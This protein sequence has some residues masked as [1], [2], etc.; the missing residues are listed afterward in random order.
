MEAIVSWIKSVAMGLVLL[1]VGTVRASELDESAGKPGDWGIRPAA[2]ETVS[3][4]PPSFSWRPQEGASSYEIR[5]GQDDSF[6]QVVYAKKGWIYNVHTPPTVLGPGTYF[7]RYRA[8]DAEGNTTEWS[9]VRDFEVSGSAKPMPLPEKNELLSRIPRRH[10]R[11]F[12]RPEQM[13]ELRRRAKSDLRPFYERLVA[14]CEQLL[15]D[16][17]PTEEPP[18]YSEDMKRGSDPWRAVWWGNRVYTQRVMNGAATLAFTWLLDGNEK[19]GSAARDLLMACAKWDPKGSTGYR[20]N[21]EAGMP[22]NYYFSRTYTFLYDL[23]S[24]EERRICRALMKVRGDEMNDHL[25]PSHFW[26]PYGSHQNRAWHFLGEIGV[27]FLDEVEG[28]D[29]WVWF[30]ANVFMNTYPVWSDD[31]GGWHEGVNYWTSYQMRF[32]WWADIM[33]AAMGIDAFQKPYYSKAGDYALYLQPPGTKGG[34]FGD[35]TARRESKDNVGLMTILA[36]QAQNPYWQWYVEAHGGAEPAQGYVGFIRGA[37]PKVK[38]KAPT[39][40]PASM[41][42]RGVGQACL[43]ATLIDAEDNVEVIFKSSPFGTWS[44]GYESQN[45]FLLYAYGERLFIRTGRRDSYGSDHHKQWMWH[46]KSV[47]SITVEGEG[48]AG[49]SQEAKGEIT[50][51]HTSDLI[52]YVEGE[53]GYAYDGKLNRFTR[54][55]VFV[56]PEVVLIYDTLEAPKNV[57]FEWRLHAPVEMTANGQEDIRVVNGAAAARASFLWPKDLAVTQTDRFDTPPRPRVKLVEYHLT[58]ATKEK[59]DRVTFV[60]LLR[61]YRSTDVLEG[62]ARIEESGEGHIVTVPLRNGAATFRLEGNEVEAE[63]KNRL[64]STLGSYMRTDG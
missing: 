16:P 36:A 9:K 4:S 21:D 26:R 58:A 5:I 33:K 6:G 43:N 40:L 8:V 18:L 54:R 64:G 31:D 42:F 2:G 38:G 19:Y 48:Q 10:P 13:D 32:T 47:N 41:V 46:T 44:H 55:I 59:S 34:G 24:E 3:L 57:T 61:P 63:V 17:P 52:D 27:T 39:D 53:A 56:K 12:V 45:A 51:F 50:A 62:E 25:N 20:Y 11:L 23:L 35:L 49:H 15:V 1:S 22:Y 30:A 29:E 7:W 37:L 14:E 28:A 60:T